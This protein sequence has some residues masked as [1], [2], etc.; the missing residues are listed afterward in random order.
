[1]LK[2]LDIASS[3]W[4]QKTVKGG[5]SSTS[6][7]RTSFS[8]SQ[9]PASSFLNFS[10]FHGTFRIRQYGAPGFPFNLLSIYILNMKGYAEKKLA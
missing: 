1:M 7:H 8:A 5:K 9:L 4:T 3:T 6:L 2:D 10:F